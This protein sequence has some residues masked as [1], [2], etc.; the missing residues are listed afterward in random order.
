MQ[1]GQE[2]E[3]ECLDMGKPPGFR[4]IIHRYGRGKLLSAQWWWDDRR[5]PIPQVGQF[6]PSMN[7]YDGTYCIIIIFPTE[8]GLFADNDAETPVESVSILIPI[9]FLW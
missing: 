3:E 1:R 9:A 7:V 4:F 8:A 6:S 2:K 5:E